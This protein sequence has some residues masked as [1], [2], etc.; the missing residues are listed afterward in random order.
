MNTSKITL[1]LFPI[2]VFLLPEGIVRLRIFEPRY[3]KMVKIALEGSGFV[4]I[5][6]SIDNNTEANQSKVNQSIINHWGSWVEI[7]NFDQ[8]VDG[9]LEVDVKC[10]SLVE[11]NNINSDSNNLKFCEAIAFPHWSQSI[12]E[13][14][15]NAL[16]K[17]LTGLLNSE[18]LLKEL[19]VKTKI[20]DGAWVAARWLELLP[21]SAEV[22][23][24]F[25]NEYNFSQATMFIETVLSK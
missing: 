20:N 24:S 11:V 21:V 13:K 23:N 17:P 7:I 22:K 8:G 18:A 6:N 9:I 10:K 25:V 1:P 3:L 4:I 19:Y 12:E 2:P 5:F 16:S 15:P 14:A